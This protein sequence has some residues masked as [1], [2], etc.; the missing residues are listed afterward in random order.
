MY[1]VTWQGQGLGGVPFL[2]SGGGGLEEGPVQ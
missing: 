1:D 2:M